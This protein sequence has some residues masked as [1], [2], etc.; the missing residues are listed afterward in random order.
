MHSLILQ[1]TTET[2]QPNYGSVGWATHIATQK[3]RAH[4]NTEMISNQRHFRQKDVV[5]IAESSIP[6]Q[7]HKG[8]IFKVW[9][10]QRLGFQLAQSRTSPGIYI[11]R[12]DPYG[13]IALC[14]AFKVG[15][16][17]FSID[18]RPCPPSMEQLQTLLYN[19]IG[20]I[21][22]HV[23]E[24]QCPNN[25]DLPFL[26]AHEQEGKVTAIKESF[27]NSTHST[28]CVSDIDSV[29][30]DSD[31]FMLPTTNSLVETSDED[32][33]EEDDFS[34]YT[35]STESSW[36]SH[37]R[38]DGNGSLPLPL[39]K[40]ISTATSKPSIPNQRTKKVE[41]KP[42]VVPDDPRKHAKSTTKGKSLPFPSALATIS[43]ATA[44]MATAKRMTPRR[45]V[46]KDFDKKTENAKND[47]APKSTH[48]QPNLVKCDD[49]VQNCDSHHIDDENNSDIEEDAKSEVH[50][51]HWSSKFGAY[52]DRLPSPN[53]D[54]DASKRNTKKPN[55]S[56]FSR[57]S[58]WDKKKPNRQTSNDSQKTETTSH[59]TVNKQRELRRKM[60]QKVL[61][62]EM[63]AI[64]PPKE[65]RNTQRLSQLQRSP[66]SQPVQGSTNDSTKYG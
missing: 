38:E 47:N 41:K 58:S 61:G 6:F 44:A 23:V 54:T 34:M 37:E 40:N 65:Q 16:R 12:I 36:S 8:T 15:M 19:S 66:Q 3:H 62:K 52:N 33:E 13:P 1:P 30:K 43:N 18:S 31:P 7:I 5:S 46:A 11:S 63:L 59:R 35:N 27:T 25:T 2:R 10:P 26:S 22:F 24:L 17:V 64:R 39:K 48:M 20:F 60:A 28:D 21:T 14:T 55:S 32:D 56:S 50:G 53:R 49:G 45:F 51:P 57:L 4:P 42:K 9:R 29:D